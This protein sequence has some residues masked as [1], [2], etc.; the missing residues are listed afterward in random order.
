M[1]RIDYI[2]S[3]LQEHL[4][5]TDMYEQLS[6]SQAHN[7]MKKVEKDI[8]NIIL[9]NNTELS[10]SDKKFCIRSFHLKNRIPTFYGMPKLHKK[11]IGDHY[12]TRPVV[13]KIS[14][15]IKIV[16]KFCDYCFSRLIPNVQSYLKDSFTLLRDIYKIEQLPSTTKLLTAGAV[17]MYTNIDTNHGLVIFSDF[18]RSHVLSD[19]TFPTYTVINY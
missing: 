12:Q 14:S 7:R 1:K 9:Y 2:K 8:K 10:S 13:A 5:Q 15:F 6:Y 19:P 18:I 16:S 17:S 3:I 4:L 11:K